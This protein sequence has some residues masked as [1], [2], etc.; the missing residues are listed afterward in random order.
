[1]IGGQGITERILFLQ[2]GLKGDIQIA[3]VRQGKRQASDRP[4]EDIPSVKLP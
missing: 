4:Y 3:K 2:E 1:M